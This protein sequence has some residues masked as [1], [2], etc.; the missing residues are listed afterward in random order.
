MAIHNR[1]TR[2]LPQYHA[3][4]NIALGADLCHLHSPN[5]YPTCYLDSFAQMRSVKCLQLFKNVPNL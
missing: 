4:Q 2:V 1:H 5:T 3:A